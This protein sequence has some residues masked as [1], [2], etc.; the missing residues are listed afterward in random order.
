LYIRFEYTADFSVVCPLATVKFK[1]YLVRRMLVQ[2]GSN[3]SVT[4]PDIAKPGR[5]QMDVTSILWSL[6][7][8][9]EHNVFSYQVKFQHL[10]LKLHSIMRLER[11]E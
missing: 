3:Q 6:S 5:I 4:S 8:F 11:V 1:Q 2:R 10:L 7:D 9:V